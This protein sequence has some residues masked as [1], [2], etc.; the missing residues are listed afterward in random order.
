MNIGW[1]VQEIARHEEQTIYNLSLSYVREGGTEVV[2]ISYTGGGC[3][4]VWWLR[5]ASEHYPSNCLKGGRVEGVVRAAWNEPAVVHI[6]VALD[7][8]GHL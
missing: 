8:G 7:Y 5:A 4:A 6:S 2:K 1:A 3:N